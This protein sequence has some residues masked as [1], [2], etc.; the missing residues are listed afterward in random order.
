MAIKTTTSIIRV[1]DIDGTTSDD[2]K[3]RRYTIDV[4]MELSD[5]NHK[6]ISDQIA[7]IFAKGRPVRKTGN[8]I[9]AT[10]A[11]NRKVRKW[12]HA[13]GKKV[14]LS[15][16]PSKRIQAEYVAATGDSR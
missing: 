11:W 6:L 15:G 5:A 13:N 9:A 12:A 2:V 1:D 10:R 8:T 4:E 7:D 14:S 3:T 16:P